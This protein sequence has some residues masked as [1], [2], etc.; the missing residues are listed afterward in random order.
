MKDKL[1]NCAYKY[2]LHNGQ[3]VSYLES[4]VIA[5]KHYHWDCAERKQKIQECAELYMANVEDKKQ[6]PVVLKTINTLVFKYRVPIDYIIK[7]I[8]N[9]PEYYKGK[10]VYAL[11]GLRTLFWTREFTV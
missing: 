11:Y 5:K 2:C 9:S 4:V 8:S 6:Y 10:P 7:Q 3:K 1:F